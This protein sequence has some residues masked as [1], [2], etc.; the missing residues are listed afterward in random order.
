MNFEPV[1]GRTYVLT[2]GCGVVTSF[3]RWFDKL[4]NP[5]YGMIISASVCAYIAATAVKT[6]SE[7]RAGVQTKIA[8]AQ[9]QASP[10]SIVEQVE[11]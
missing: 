10:P 2:V 8:E 6:H 5:T 11:K 7:I 4:D 9:A 3:M 1:G